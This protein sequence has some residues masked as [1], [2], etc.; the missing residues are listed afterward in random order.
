MKIIKYVIG[1]VAITVLITLNLT[2][3]MGALLRLLNPLIICIVLCLYRIAK[4][5]T[6][7]D[8]A[9]G[10]D[11]LGIL[12]VG[13]CAFFSLITKKDFFIDIAAAWALQ[14]FIGTIAL[15]KY[16]EGKRLDE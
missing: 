8:R 15:A 10:V 2:I 12:V 13:C 7:A 4:G 1:L 11:I 16:L 5:P 3:K 6:P 9:V 14:S